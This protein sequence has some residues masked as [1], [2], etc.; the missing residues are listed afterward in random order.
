MTQPINYHYDLHTGVFTGELPARESPAE[1]GEFLLP[2]G[3][4]RTPP[5]S[6]PVGS[7]ARFVAG[8]GWVVVDD[9]RGVWYGPDRAARFIDQFDTD[10]AGLVRAAPPSVNHD[11]VGGVWVL[12]QARAIEAVQA[13]LSRIV[14]TRL[15]AF[16]KEKEYDDI[17]SLV[18]YAGDPDPTL[19]AEGTLGEAK[20][21]QTWVKMKQIR[22]EVLAG[23]RPMPESIEDIEAELPSL[24][25]PA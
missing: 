14:Q 18:T 4:T 16:A 15:D 19:N 13:E 9:A 3:A 10:L 22:A 1:P 12:N 21:S 11:L 20:R 24:V 5:P 2:L 8:S 23:T 7:V 25:W 17:K 6:A